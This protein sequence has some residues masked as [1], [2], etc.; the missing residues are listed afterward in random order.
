[1]GAADRL[2]SHQLPD[3]GWPWLFDA[4]TD[5]VVERYELYSVHQHAMGPMGFLQLAEASG[6]QR[7][8]EAAVHGLGWID[9]QN[10]LGQDMVDR[11]NQMILRSIRRRPRSS[12]ACLYANTAGELMLGRTLFGAARRPELNAT[13]RPYE[14]GWLL[15]AWCG[16]ERFARSE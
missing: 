7:Y 15:E 5:R 9:G 10:E 12:R 6:E 8:A 1:M 11:E 13:C 3:G 14:L 4:D 2:M 16:R